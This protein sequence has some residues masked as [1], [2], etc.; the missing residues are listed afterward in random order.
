MFFGF[1]V[2]DAYSAYKCL[3]NKNYQNLE[4]NLPWVLNPSPNS[5][6]LAAGASP[7]IDS[8]NNFE[9]ITIPYP[10]AGKYTI[11]IKGKFLPDNKV[12]FILLSHFDE[13]VLRLTSPIGGEKYN[14]LEV[15]QIHYK[16]LSSDSIF[17]RFSPN[18]G[19]TWNN[20]RGVPGN[21]RLVSWTVLNNI[22]SD[23]CL[24]E[25]KQELS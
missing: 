3:E 17:I 25:I 8:L 16:S 23:S 4:I 9:Q 11:R 6:T 13:K 20:V 5:A 22:I 18:G 1:G 24:I 21:S 14:S 15:T 2:I 7:G 10:V 12:P 19:R